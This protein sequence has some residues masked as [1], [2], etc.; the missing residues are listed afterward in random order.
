MPE[1]DWH[2]CHFCGELV[3]D[4]HE[5][6]PTRRHWLSDCRPDLVRHEIGPTCTWAFRTLENEGDA[7]DLEQIQ[8]EHLCYAFEWMG[9][10]TN[11][12]QRVWTSRHIHFYNDGPM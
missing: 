7:V 11:N 3:K 6:D 12:Y 8:R 4:G 1:E 9:D 2:N 10:K 5:V